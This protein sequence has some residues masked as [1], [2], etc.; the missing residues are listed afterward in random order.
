MSMLVGTLQ[1]TAVKPTRLNGGLHILSNFESTKLERM[2]QYHSFQEF[3]EAAVREVGLNQVGAAWH[4]FD[5]GG[6]TGVLCLAESHLSIHTWPHENY[7][8]FDIY[9]SNHTR[10]NSPSAKRIYEQ[11]LVFFE[12]TII[13]EK[14]ITR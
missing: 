9:L 11:V 6:F 10:D 3:V 7:I 12:A 5:G 1:E 4:N 8:T 13:K 2:L 14:S